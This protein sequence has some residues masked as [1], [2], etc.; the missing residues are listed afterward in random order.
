MRC[1]RAYVEEEVM[2]DS[3]W[4]AVSVVVASVA[5]LASSFQS[6]IAYSARQ[7]PIKAQ[8]ISQVV[9]R[10]SQSL[11]LTT[12]IWLAAD[13]LADDIT[14]SRN[15]DMERPRRIG[16]DTRLLFQTTDFLRVLFEAA[17]PGSA[18]ALLREQVTM[19]PSL[20]TLIDSTW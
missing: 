13:G 18:E 1:G 4:T 10:C 19:N 6:Y 7:Q 9:E 11:R 12:N 16:D 2:A 8:V 15:F 14:R 3:P 17:S 20:R 5:A